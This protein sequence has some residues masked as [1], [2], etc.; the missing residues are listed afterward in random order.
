MPFRLRMELINKAISKLEDSKR[1]RRHNRNIDAIY[2]NS[3]PKYTRQLTAE[4]DKEAWLK[5]YEMQSNN[6]KNARS[7]REVNTENDN[8]EKIINEFKMARDALYGEYEM[9]RYNLSEIWNKGDDTK[10]F[11]IHSSD[12]S[13]ENSTTEYSCNPTDCTKHIG[14]TMSIFGALI[15][16]TVTLLK[17]IKKI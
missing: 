10:N 17:L 14:I 8:F 16:L 5:A 3:I 6:A 11:T 9:K 4:E 7:K 13:A 1:S 15:L 2:L 12:N